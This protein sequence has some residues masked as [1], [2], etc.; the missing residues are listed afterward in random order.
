MRQARRILDHQH[1]L[2]LRFAH[3]PR[4]SAPRPLRRSAPRPS[5]RLLGHRAGIAGSGTHAR[6]PAK[7]TYGTTG[8]SPLM[9]SATVSDVGGA[10]PKPA[11]DR[12]TVRGTDR[13]GLRRRGRRAGTKKAQLKRFFA[14]V[15]PVWTTPRLRGHWFYAWRRRSGWGRTPPPGKGPHKMTPSRAPRL[16]ARDH[17]RLKPLSALTAAKLQH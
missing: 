17:R 4:R 5:R 3:W 14:S 11:A 13:G 2:R 9:G 8:T 1:Q 12:P 7:I 10:S 15:H 16:K 6:S